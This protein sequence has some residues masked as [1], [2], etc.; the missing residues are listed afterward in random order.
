MD[1][2]PWGGEHVSPYPTATAY[3]S[4]TDVPTNS[5]TDNDNA[6]DAPV[7]AEGMHDVA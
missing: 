2:S 3:P 5:N 4:S 6:N 7:Q 1:D